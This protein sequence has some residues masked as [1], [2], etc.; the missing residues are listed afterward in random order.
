MDFGIP[1]EIKHQEYRVAMLPLQVQRLVTRGHRVVVQAGAGRG[2]GFEDSHYRDAGAHIADSAKQVYAEADLILKVKEPQPEELDSYREEQ[3]LFCYIH[4]ETRPKLVEMLLDK[5]MTGLAFENVRS[6]DGDRPLLK[7]MST[8]AGQ[9]AVLQ[10]MQ[11]LCNHRGGTGTS[12][13]RYP[14]L[15][16]ARVVVLGGGHAGIAAAQVAAAL[17]AEVS[18]FEA[19]LAK[20]DRLNRRLPPNVQV[21][22]SG[23]VPLN[24]RV[25][26]ADLV[27][28]TTT[29]PPN[30][31]VKLIDR[32][33]VRKMRPGAVI[34]DVTANLNGAIETVDRYTTHHDPVYTTDGVIHYVVTNVPGTVAR[35]ASQ[36]LAM[37]TAPYVEALA[38][39]GIR[40]AL[41][42][43]PGLLAGLTCINGILT[44]HEAGDRLGLPWVPPES[45]ILS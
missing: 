43:D 30:S 4:S 10:S 13:V 12:L 6:S 18:L 38:E 36:A 26:D 42:A 23:S 20:I 31:P 5:R 11:F 39:H 14:G 21:C 35:T 41:H 15:A 27:I 25:V 17:G 22:Y 16:P 37:A 3:T 19:D 29:I 40:Q 9:Q 24:E 8:V 28:H 32:A 7:P 44:W 2:A 45:A 34:A 1:R 33:T